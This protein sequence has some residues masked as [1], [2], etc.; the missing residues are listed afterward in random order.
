[1]L[2]I[3]IAEDE[4]HNREALSEILK[5]MGH[6]PIAAV[7]GQEALEKLSTMAIDLVLSDV[8]MPRMDG[9]QFF[10]AFR[11]LFSGG[12]E[13]PFVFMTAYGRL[14][15]A[16]EAMRKGALNFLSKPL[17]KKDILVVVEDAERLLDARGRAGSSESAAQNRHEAIYASR[18]F[19]EVAAL[20]DKV[21]PT[22][23]SVLL[24]GESGTGKEVLARRLHERSNRA[25][26]PFV[27]FHAGATPETLLESELFGFE[28]GAFTGAEQSRMGQ[29]RSAHRGTFFIDELSSMPLALQAK[30]LRVL[31]ERAVHPLGAQAPVDVDVRWVAAT[32]TELEPLVEQG[33][34]RED[35]LYR[36]R[37]VVIEIPPLRARP[38]DIEVLAE[39]FMQGF[40][41]EAGRAPLVMHQATR[42]LLREYAWPGNVRELR[43]VIERAVALSDGAEFEPRLLPDHLA[44]A[45]R[46]REIRVAVGSSLQSVEDRLIEETLRSC[47]GDKGQAA[48]I[49]GVA[50]RTIYRWLERR[51]E[52]GTS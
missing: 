45:S 42:S 1:M 31:Q 12:A 5:R 23:A 43:N 2:R 16:V 46:S 10:D 35:L 26:H 21:A 11:Q 52:R 44:Q 22:L 17:R 19:A 28:K 14:E 34:F 39:H 9:L 50:P 29:V 40:C 3:L 38:E 6:E 37:V 13:P 25:S 33:R 36:L 24:V 4:A 48:A 15:E 18:A 30:L 20:V 8:R 27:A 32:N 41:A 49:L 47:N 51:E 7:D